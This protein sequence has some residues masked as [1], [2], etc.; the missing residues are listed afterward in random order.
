MGEGDDKMADG[1]RRW[2]DGRWEREVGGGRGRWDDR[3]RREMVEENGSWMKEM[4]E[5]DGRWER[6]LGDG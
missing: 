6:E 1:R 3:R 5:E 4:D 2:Q